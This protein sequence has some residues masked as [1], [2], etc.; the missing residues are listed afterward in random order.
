MA[1]SVWI[2]PQST[3]VCFDRSA[4][5]GT[6]GGYVG[7]G[8]A[9]SNLGARVLCDLMLERQSDLTRLA[10]VDDTPRRWEPEPL[11][12][13]GYTAGNLLAG[14]ADNQEMRSGKPARISGALLDKL[15]W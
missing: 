7:D 15:L 1:K 3:C 5:M 2:A 10:W 13:L 8:V 4:G 11:R 6:A 12:W 9:A 14:I